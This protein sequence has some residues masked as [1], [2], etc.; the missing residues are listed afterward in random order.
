MLV[1]TEVD[2]SAAAKKLNAVP[3]YNVVNHWYF[4][5]CDVWDSS[6]FEIRLVEYVVALLATA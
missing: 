1:P 6:N 2:R 4:R 3:L 5:S